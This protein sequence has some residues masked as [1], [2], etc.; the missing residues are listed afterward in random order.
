MEINKWK[1]QLVGIISSQYCKEHS[2]QRSEWHTVN[3]H[4]WPG[5]TLLGPASTLTAIWVRWVSKAWW[6]RF[7]WP[8][9][10]P[11][12][13]NVSIGAERPDSSISL[14]RSRHFYCAVRLILQ[15]TAL[16]PDKS[17]QFFSNDDGGSLGWL[18]QSETP[19]SPGKLHLS[20][21]PDPHQN[22]ILS[23]G[24][25]QLW[26]LR[27]WPQPQW[28]PIWGANEEAAEIHPALLTS[29]PVPANSLLPCQANP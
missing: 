11:G 1:I 26:V 22:K 3:H 2:S 18:V 5:L 12:S 9:I 13:V 10:S 25:I 28:W 6:E 24:E 19:T 16:G 17:H 29:V 8:S 23:F 27:P 14:Q 15:W 7:V 20:A 21:L 4:R